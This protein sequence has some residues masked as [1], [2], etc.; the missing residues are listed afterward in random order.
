[1]AR[2]SESSRD[3]RKAFLILDPEVVQHLYEWHGGQFTPTY[4]LASTGQNNLVSP[5]MIED[6]ISELESVARKQRGKLKKDI[7]ALIG[8]LDAVVSYP[9]E[10]SAREAGMDIA[11][12][13]Y[14]YYDNP[15]KRFMV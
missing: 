10:H 3:Y 14:E 9:Q 13:E 5:K 4:A 6:A 8:D 1:M 15:W 7:N 2:I 11:E 12:S